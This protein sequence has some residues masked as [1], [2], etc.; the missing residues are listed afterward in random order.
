M[1]DTPIFP[2]SLCGKKFYARMD[3]KLHQNPYYTIVD[4]PKIAPKKRFLVQYKP[5]PPMMYCDPKGGIVH[6]N[7]NG[8]NKFEKQWYS[9]IKQ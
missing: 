8:Q 7:L 9:K 1:S 5:N 4:C 2:C 3:L 6:T